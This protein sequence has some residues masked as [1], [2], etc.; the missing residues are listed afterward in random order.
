MT[1]ER[2]MRSEDRNE[3]EQVKE[4]ECRISTFSFLEPA[5][6]RYKYLRKDSEEPLAKSYSSLPE[7]EKIIEELLRL[8]SDPNPQIRRSAIDSLL[9][10]YSLKSG[11]EQDIWNELLRISGDTDTG[12]RKGAASMLS[13]V[14]PVV[15]EKSTVFSDLVKLTESQDSQLRK[16]AAELFT[17]AFAYSDDKQKTWNDLVKLTSAEDRE[18]RREAVLALSSGYSEVPDKAKVWSDLIRLSTHGDSFVQRVAARTLGSAFFYVPDKTQAFKDLQVLIGNPYIY[19]QIYALRSLGKASLWKALKAENEAT[20]LFGLKEA[21]KYFKESNEASTSTA[22]PELYY[23]FYNALLQ[24]LFG[25]RSSKLESERYISEVTHKINLEEDKRLLKIMEEFSD[26]LLA[27][28]NLTAGDLPVRKKLL[29]ASIEAFERASG[30]LD[31]M[32]EDAIL[33][34]KNLRKECSI[35]GKVITEQKLKEIL[36]GIRY[37][38]RTACFKAKGKPTEKITCAVNERVKTWSFQDLEKDRKELDRQL[39]SLLS[40]LR[41]QIPFIPENMSIF[42]KLDDISQEQ[43][44]LER[45]RHVSRLL[46]LIPGA[47]MH[48]RASDKR[49]QRIG[50]ER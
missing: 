39:E 35:T 3:C 18:V 38:A 2:E 31:I 11:K 15:E 20:Y 27:A 26:L 16:K 47:K 30:L 36:S 25:E 10:I 17:A 4:K 40:T 21:V 50:Y 29:E 5:D 19:V 46:S 42:Q 1:R 43:C 13:R 7:K 8:S 49:I 34:Q 44:L 48:S 6:D 22:I 33:E 12:V 24:I 45:Y 9:T 23:P 14:F 41:V 32:E 37:K 28:G